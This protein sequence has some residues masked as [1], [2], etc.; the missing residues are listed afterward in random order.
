MY[1]RLNRFTGME[2]EALAGSLEWFQSEGLPA[3]RRSP[4]FL[5][6]FFGV[7][8]EEGTA[9]ALTCWSSQ[10]AMSVNEATEGPMRMEALRRAGGSLS[11]GLVDTYEIV[12]TDSRSMDSDDTR[13]HARVIRWEGLRPAAIRAAKEEFVDQELPTWTE[14]PDYRGMLLGANTTLGNTLLVCFWATEDLSDVEARERQTTR[15]ITSARSG[16]FRP[17]MFDSYQVAM[18]P[19]LTPAAATVTAPHGSSATASR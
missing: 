2:A 15:R 9:T 11:R 18:A 4:S 14:D 10:H 16:P 19:D 8:L 6:I 7:N 5:T 12:H 17:V 13:L 1:A 3:L